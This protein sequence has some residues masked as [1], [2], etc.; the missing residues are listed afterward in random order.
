MHK[1]ELLAPAG[2]LEKLKIAI[3]YGADA[4]YCG[5]HD[6]GL[7]SGADNFTLEELNAGGE[8]LER[9]RELTFRMPDDPAPVPNIREYKFIWEGK[10]ENPD[11]EDIFHNAQ[12][13]DSQSNRYADVRSMSVGDLVEIK[14][15]LYFCDIFGFTEVEW[16]H[17]T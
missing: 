5:G 11:L 13:L 4:V 14:G 16:E 2:N 6:Y 15:T 17:K 3:D 8:K 12:N 7:R 9:Y 10:L 1:P